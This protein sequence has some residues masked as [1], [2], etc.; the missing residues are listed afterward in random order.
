MTMT[1]FKTPITRPDDFK[2]V[3]TRKHYK[4]NSKDILSCYEFVKKYMFDLL[5]GLYNCPGDHSC[6]KLP[7]PSRRYIE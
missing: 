2:F 1:F 3:I 6:R 7:K 4:A 5:T